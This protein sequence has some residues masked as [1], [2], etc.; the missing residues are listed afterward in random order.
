M[1]DE[2]LQQ[3][4]T[5]SKVEIPTCTVSGRGSDLRD[6]RFLFHLKNHQ[7]LNSNDDDPFT[8]HSEDKLAQDALFCSLNEFDDEAVFD[9]PKSPAL[10]PHPPTVMLS[11]ASTS[12][13]NFNSFI[14]VLTGFRKSQFF[15]SLTTLSAFRSKSSLLS[16]K[17]A[18]EINIEVNTKNFLHAKNLSTNANLCTHIKSAKNRSLSNESGKKDK[19]RRQKL[20]QYLPV[21]ALRHMVNSDSGE[22]RNGLNC[23]GNYKKNIHK[24]RFYL[25]FGS[26]NIVA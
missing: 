8:Y 3:G 17:P 7:N 24:V 16:N 26:K 21:A 5:A 18:T 1:S 15:R 20:G 23:Y 9:I 14:N 22:L 11:S 6:N 13:K 12:K 19:L 10:I 25:I 4:D 2:V